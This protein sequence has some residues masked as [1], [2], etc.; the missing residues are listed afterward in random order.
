MTQVH[1]SYKCG[2]CGVKDQKLWHPEG[3][4]F[5]KQKLRCALCAM[6]ENK[7]NPKEMPL[8]T[9]GSHFDLDFFSPTSRIN[10]YAPALVDRFGDLRSYMGDESKQQKKRMWWCALPNH[11]EI[12]TISEKPNLDTFTATTLKSAN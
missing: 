10:T 1:E 8:H 9:D 7:I 3:E 2:N 11:P 12:I 4:F 6:K 5:G